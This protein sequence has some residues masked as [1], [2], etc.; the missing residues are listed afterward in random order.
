MKA[1]TLLLAAAAIVSAAGLP[2]NTVRGNYVEARTADVYTGPCFAMSEVNLTGDLAVM[3]WHID[4]GSY[5]GVAL[6]G[7]SVMGVV[8]ASATLGDPMVTAYPVKSVL[9]VDA[10]ANPEQQIALR[11]FAQRMAGDLLNDVVRMEVSPITFDVTNNNIHTRGASMVA[12]KLATVATRALNPGDQICHNEEVWYKPLVALDHAMA[13]YTETNS[14]G[15]SGLDTVWK[16]TGKRGS[17]V[18]TFSVNE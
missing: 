10:K 18:G 6:D 11:R 14:F 2:K 1:W 4:Q 12:G 9:I 8:H 13:A 17:Y 16:W 5:D 3:G 15:G 7:L